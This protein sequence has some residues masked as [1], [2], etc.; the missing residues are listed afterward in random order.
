MARHKEMIIRWRILF[1]GGGTL[2]LAGLFIGLIYI[3]PASASGRMLIW[4][5]SAKLCSEHI[6]W[7][8]GVDSFKADYMSAQANYLSSS[9]ASDAELQLAGDTTIHSMNI[10]WY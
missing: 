5:V 1:I 4:K 6:L 7:G 9:Q 2:I 8:N 10:C 3:K